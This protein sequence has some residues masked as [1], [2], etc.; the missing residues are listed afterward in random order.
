MSTAQCSVSS[1]ETF[2]CF[3]IIDP[4]RCSM[5]P[6]WCCEDTLMNIYLPGL[7]MS[8]LIRANAAGKIT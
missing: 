3:V 7:Y 1:L 2:S 6:D 8:L 4:T 5:I